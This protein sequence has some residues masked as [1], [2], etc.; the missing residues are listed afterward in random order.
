MGPVL[1][2]D[3]EAKCTFVSLV[4]GIVCPCALMLGDEP[5]KQVTVMPPAA[6]TNVMLFETSTHK[7]L[8]LLTETQRRACCC[9][10]CT[11]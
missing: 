7:L 8:Q 9:V 10:A 2:T 6:H 11:G 1:Q 3:L 5:E 4:Q